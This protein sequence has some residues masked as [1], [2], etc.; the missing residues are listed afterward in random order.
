MEGEGETS[1]FRELLRE[2]L[3]WAEGTCGL[4]GEGERERRTGAAD[5]SGERERQTRAADGTTSGERRVGRSYTSS[6]ML[7]ACRFKRTV[8]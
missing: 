2:R 8:L 7:Y 3:R 4:E 6:T 1:R 5:G